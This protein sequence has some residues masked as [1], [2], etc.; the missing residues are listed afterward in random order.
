MQALSDR[1]AAE[2][3]NVGAEHAGLVVS[4]VNPDGPAAEKLT[5]KGSPSGTDIIT[6]INGQRVRT[7][8]EMNEVL[9]GVQPGEVVSLRT[10]T[11]TPDGTGVGRTVRIRTSTN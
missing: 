11:I 8:A 2:D 6:H 10:Y 9:K 7:V 1:E 3:Q 4:E 5:P